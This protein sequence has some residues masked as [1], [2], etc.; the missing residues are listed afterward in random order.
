MFNRR[1]MLS[2]LAAAIGG[3]ATVES[4]EAKRP[5][6]IKVTLPEGTS[7]ETLALIA[8]HHGSRAFDN[9]PLR[10]LPVFF[11]R[12]GIEDVEIIDDPRV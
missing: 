8:E 3:G 12:R 11:V 4:M 1:Q 10:G 7:D 5:L 2:S 6:A 9:T